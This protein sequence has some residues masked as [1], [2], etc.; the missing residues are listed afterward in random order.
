ME[1]DKNNIDDL[2][3]RG[4]QNTYESFQ[5]A[6]WELMKERLDNDLNKRKIKRLPFLYGAVAAAAITLF[7][8]FYPAMLQQNQK[9]GKTILT[10]RQIPSPT[11]KG[12]KEESGRFAGT[13]TSGQEPIHSRKDPNLT[14][15]NKKIALPSG[16]D[17][18]RL[19][20]PDNLPL[21]SLQNVLVPKMA[22][23]IANLQTPEIRSS[24]SSTETAGYGSAYPVVSNRKDRTN[25]S[26]NRLGG[27]L[28]ILAAP[29]LTSVRG[30]GHPSLSQNIG[31]L[32]THP[33]SKRLSITIGAI[34]AR[35]NYRSAYS[36]YTPKHPPASSR[37][38][39]KVDA[40]CD[41]IDAPLLINYNLLQLKNGIKLRIST[42]MSSYFM[43]RERYNFEYTGN[44]D[45]YSSYNQPYGSYEVK[46]ENKHIM[47]IADFSISAEKKISDKIN[48]GI[49][50]FL[51]VPLTGIGYGR[52]KLESKGLAVTLGVDL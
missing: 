12:S 8:I 51:K 5:E 41:V 19:A 22:P 25:I 20:D 18:Q 10:K 24:N 43:L 46:G 26:S 16:S 39:D 15:S 17:K 29:D 1:K 35:K 28:S 13:K 49:R 30:A 40:N 6:H 3:K 48:I 42:G 45:Y 9:A 14:A 4:L 50:P 27:T 21:L 38:P 33:V 47:G 31:L 37:L 36:F 32:Y 11:S 2:F 44:G 34:Y 52:T 7:F 23:E